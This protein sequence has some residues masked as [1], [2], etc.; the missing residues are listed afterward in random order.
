MSDPK[1]LSDHALLVWFGYFLTPKHTLSFGGE[2][3]EMAI[4]PECRAALN[5]LVEFGAVRPVGAKAGD[6]VGR[7]RFGATTTCLRDEIKKRSGNDPFDWAQKNDFV[8]FAK[9]DAA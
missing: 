3:A 1:S 6:P 5:E 9:K 4:T 2:A 7:E 8:N